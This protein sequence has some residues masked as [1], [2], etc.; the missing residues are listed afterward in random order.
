[1]IENSLNEI[2]FELRSRL[3]KAKKKS[4]PSV[5][6]ESQDK[7]EFSSPLSFPDQ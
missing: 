1:M 4:A 7:A 6:L 2:L 3:S 5:F